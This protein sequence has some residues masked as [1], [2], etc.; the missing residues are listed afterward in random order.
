MLSSVNEKSVFHTTYISMPTITRNV[1]HNEHK[2][3]LLHVYTYA[4][5]ICLRIQSNLEWQNP[6]PK[7]SSNQLVALSSNLS[8]RS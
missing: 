2:F 8:V 4:A 5:I 6:P 3:Q 7:E 1:E